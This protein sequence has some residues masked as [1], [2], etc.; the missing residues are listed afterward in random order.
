MYV[1]QLAKQFNNQLERSSNNNNKN[2]VSS[3]HPYDN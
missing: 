2:D 1:H 3:Y